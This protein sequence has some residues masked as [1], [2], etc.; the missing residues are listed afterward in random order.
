M[1]TKL[2]G[3]ASGSTLGAAVAGTSGGV[4]TAEILGVRGHK[5]GLVAERKFTVSLLID[6][7]V[8]E[9]QL[10]FTDETLNTRSIRGN[11][12]GRHLT[13]AGIA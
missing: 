8:Y 4:V 7:E 9:L 12:K 1:A 11:R 6:A 10:Q 2:Y 5:T 3:S 13:A